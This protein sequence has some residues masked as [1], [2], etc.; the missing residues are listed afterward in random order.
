MK[1]EIKKRAN[2]GMLAGY[3]IVS[4]AMDIELP[5]TL[6]P[7]KIFINNDPFLFLFSLFL[8]FYILFVDL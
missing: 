2:Y 3:I 5:V 6:A 8:F 1:Y 4:T 7:W